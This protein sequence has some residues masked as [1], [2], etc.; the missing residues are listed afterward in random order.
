MVMKRIDEYLLGKG[1][2]NVPEHLFP[3]LPI[4]D[5]IIDFLEYQGFERKNFENVDVMNR[6]IETKIIKKLER[7]KNLSYIFINRH[8]A[9][10]NSIY[11]SKG[12]KITEDN[13][14][15]K[16]LVYKDEHDINSA[17]ISGKLYFDSTTYCKLDTEYDHKEYEKLIKD[18]NKYFEF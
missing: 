8:Y 7:S 12:G 14:C 4:E 15:V 1:K 16:I 2:T 3:K 5:D 6:K 9:N 11:F 13:P 18:I 10:Y 17:Y